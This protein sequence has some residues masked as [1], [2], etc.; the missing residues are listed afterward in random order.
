MSLARSFLRRE[1]RAI[2]ISLALLVAGPALVALLLPRESHTTATS[3]AI[4][5]DAARDADSDGLTD[6]DEAQRWGTSPRQPDSDGDGLPDAW[7][8]RH[9]RALLGTTRVCP[10]PIAP[11]AGADCVGKGVTLAQDHA[12]GT[13]PHARD[14]DRDG[15]EDAIE[16]RLAMDPLR[17]DA[18]DDPFGDGLTNRLRALLGARADRPDTACSGMMDAEKARRGL[19]PAR[20]ST[21][22]SGVP[23]GWA[24]HFGLDAADPTIGTLRLD[25]DPSGLTVAE[26]ARYSADR[27]DLCAA[28]DRAPPFERGLDPRRSD[29]DGDGLPDAWEVAHGLDALD[30]SDARADPDEDGLDN[31]DERHY[32]AC[33]LVDDCDRDGLRDIEEAVVGWNVTVDGETR[34]VHSHPRRAVTDGETIPDGAKRAGRWEVDG[35]ALTFPPLDPNTP[36][37]DGDDLSD[38]A[39][40]LRFAGALRPDRKDT[41][42]DGL[43]DGEEVLYWDERGGEDCAACDTD[44]DGL[45][46]AADPDADGDGILDGEEL[47]PRPRAVAPGSPTRAPFPASDPARADTDEDGLPDAWEARHARYVA[48]LGA[49]DLDPSRD[50]SLQSARGC[51]DAETCADGERDLD[52]D[53]LPNALELGATTDPQDADTDDDGLPDGWE[54]AYGAM[55]GAR[56][57]RLPIQGRGF[58]WLLEP[59]AVAPLSPLDPGDAQGEIARYT[60][61]RYGA[62]GRV[63]TTLR[64]TYLDLHRVGAS[65]VRPASGADGLPDLYKA[66]WLT[67][68]PAAFDTPDADRDGRTNVEEFAA[69]TDPLARDSDRG[70][71]DDAAEA[72]SGLDPLEP[73]DDAGEGDLDGDGLS[74]GDELHVWGTR[75]DAPDT[76]GD[77]L[78]DGP[79]LTLPTAS[80]LARRLLVK[81]IAHRAE[82]GS[83]RFLGEHR[84]S[85]DPAAGCARKW[86]CSGDGLPD[87]WKVHYGIDAASFHPPTETR[88]SDGLPIMLEYTWGRPAWWDEAEHGPW[89]LGLDP[90]RPDTNRDGVRDDRYTRAGDLADLDRDG[91]N[92]LTGEDPTPFHDVADPT[93]RQ[94]AFAALA[95]RAAPR[96]PPTWPPAALALHTPLPA[97]LEKGRTLT[98]NGT[99]SPPVP[100]VPILARLVADDASHARTSRPELVHGLAFTRA[101]GTFTLDLR[102]A[103]DHKVDVPATVASVFAAKPPEQLAW[104]ADTTRLRLGQTHSLVLWSHA[105]PGTIGSGSLVPNATVQV[106][107]AARIAVPDDVTVAPGRDARFN[108]TLQDGAGDPRPVAANERL[109]LHWNG[110]SVPP[111]AVDGANATFLLTLAR[112]APAEALRARITYAGDA[113][114]GEGEQTIRVVPRLAT[115]LT[116]HDPPRS[117]YVGSAIELQGALSDERGRPLPHA[118]AKATFAGSSAN[119][120]TDP[121]GTFSLAI[122][123]P[124]STALGSRAP[125]VEYEGA[126]HYAAATAQGPAVAIRARPELVDLRANATLGRI[127]IAAKLLAAGRPVLDPS[128]Q[129]PPRVTIAA[130]GITR[131]V[132]P[133]REG[134]VRAVLAGDPLAHPG[135]VRVDLLASGS[136]LVDAAIA[137]L[138]VAIAAR[139]TLALDDARATRGTNATLVGSLRDPTGAP[140]ADAIVEI[141]LAGRNATARTNAEGA[142]RAAVPVSPDQALGLVV[143][144]ARFPGKDIVHLP[145]TARADVVVVAGTSMRASP[146]VLDASEATLSLTF[147][148]DAGAPRAH[149]LVGIVIDGDPLGS[150]LTNESGALRLTIPPAHRDAASIRLRAALAATTRHAAFDETT[151]LLVEQPTTLEIIEAPREARPGE[152]KELRARLVTL[153]G[154]AVSNASIEIAFGDTAPTSARTNGALASIVLVIPDDAVLGP[155]PVLARFA[156][157]DRY[158]ASEASV[159]LLVRAEPDVRA[160]REGGLLLVEVAHPH[161]SL[162]GLPVAIDVNGGSFVV[163]TDPQGRAAFVLGSAASPRVRLLGSPELRPTEIPAPAAPAGAA[164]AR[165]EAARVPAWWV[166]A[167]VAAALAAALAALLYAKHRRKTAEGVA[168]ALVEAERAF[169]AR[170]EH[171]ALVVRAYHALASALAER[172][173]APAAATPRETQ[174][175]L[176][177]AFRLPHEDL[178]LVVTAFERAR[179]G[180]GST[181]PHEATRVTAA[182]SRLRQALAEDAP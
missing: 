82:G 20:A 104:E 5:L 55:S 74:N 36:D 57:G 147:V 50:D 156:G 83:T 85:T 29:S 2:A 87:A 27:I 86:S 23:D 151:L 84:V 96:Q 35:R 159:T 31:L 107:S 15:I 68:D 67:E 43:A 69:G 70:G 81:G 66:I 111:L 160:T 128:T 129:A 118:R 124:P 19:D 80:P 61:V 24:V 54:H 150:F 51:K 122:D 98:L 33:P 9:S 56:A 155:T 25:D 30:A 90:T 158:R 65:P 140:L 125:I 127:E 97:T 76:D 139:A 148:D 45:E 133:T 123:V 1:R 113:T 32:D 62:S 6:L 8:A 89:W 161:A 163:E 93:D 177:R 79:D 75:L 141:Q 71:L 175:V 14:T 12:A 17:D 157:E 126:P 46:N 179:Y 137:T 162:D 170:D 105:V 152:R 28:A 153:A 119:T 169:L 39:E 130:G 164:Q 132:T 145:T 26:K 135:I 3:A 4:T 143:A 154:A 44:G 95:T 40:I 91:R 18:D 106:S 176:A 77:A 21:G 11:D 103:R 100:A 101:D 115:A 146:R 47:R 38:A 48:D 108:A 94:A 142:F 134:D 166:A 174:A 58:E 60:F 117:T 52:D 149:E 168:A 102:L 167:G 165:A 88:T 37:T 172:G 7:E 120:T 116:I 92:D 144:H 59:G 131:E 42:G 173:L 13:D 64:W 16:I 72:A 136:S 112:D 181:P 78:L 49:W 10:D 110:F 73:G 114:L 121:N 178:D 34:R 99:L 171:A 53:G 182:L 109:A 63:E 41:D 138:D 180:C 22:G